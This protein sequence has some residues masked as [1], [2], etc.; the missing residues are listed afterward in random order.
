LTESEECNFPS[1]E[2]TERRRWK[3]GELPGVESLTF[4]SDA[5]QTGADIDIQIAHRNA[6]RLEKLAEK[7]K[8]VLHYTGF[9]RIYSIQ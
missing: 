7:I 8:T 9:W 1:S 3:V 5:F 2:I 6:G 4:T